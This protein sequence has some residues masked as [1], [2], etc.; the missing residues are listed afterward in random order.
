ML[1]W[2][3]RVG[4]GPHSVQPTLLCS[5]RSVLQKA[6]V[7]I[8][9]IKA[10]SEKIYGIDW[11]RRSANHLIT[12]SL[13]KTVKFWS[14]LQ[15]ND[16][17]LTITTSSPVWRARHLPFGHGVLTLPQRSDTSLQLWS[18]DRPEESV[19]TFSGH[20]DTVREFVW[21]VRGGS[22]ATCDDRQFQL[23][24]WGKDCKLRLWPVSDDVLR[25]VGHRPGAPIDVRVTRT[26]ASNRT[27]RQSSLSVPAAPSP[28]SSMSPVTSRGGMMGSASS[29]KTPAQDQRLSWERRFGA[30]PPRDLR[31][32][33]FRRPGVMTRA[34]TTFARPNAEDRLAWMEG[35]KLFKKGD[36]G[37]DAPQV[38]VGKPRETRS[39]SRL[40]SAA[41]VESSEAE[42]PQN[43]GEE[44]RSAARTF[45]R[46]VF[47]TIA[48]QARTCS[49][50]LYGPWAAKRGVAFL[51][52]TFTFP[53]A[54]PARKPPTIEIER[55]ADVTARTRAGL[56]KAAREIMLKHAAEGSPSFEAC[57][58]FLLGEK[59]ESGKK[60]GA[61]G[62]EGS[63]DS[64]DEEEI[65]SRIDPAILRNNVNVPLPARG[66]ACF[67]PQG[68]SRRKLL[69]SIPR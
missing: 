33:T 65:P 63:S 30:R 54:Y 1:V 12:C 2:D 62:I 17:S 58:Q 32:R 31:S 40:S 45:S 11:S 4:C 18:K 7:P 35:V 48:V 43:L 5:F 67:G 16:P 8:I 49:V 46:V 13:D 10:H 47:E 61:A 50:G 53:K 64:E 60:V 68:L 56:L 6:A 9:E 41:A 59:A 22:D 28:P 34:T 27:Y 25:S 19:A 69:H 21:R 39:L 36:T 29:A 3:A 51:R 26:G 66:G 42:P 20:A 23:V 38:T 44:L 15:P 14:T 55:S 37:Q 52:A 57:L 24:T